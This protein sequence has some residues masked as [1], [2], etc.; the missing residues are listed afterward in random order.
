MQNFTGNTSKNKNQNIIILSDFVESA[1]ESVCF[2]IEN[3]MLNNHE[4][5][6]VQTYKRPKFG[7]MLLKNITPVLKQI[8]KNDLLDLKFKTL[9]HFKIDEG[10]VSIHP[11]EG[12][13]KSV[14]YYKRIF[15]NSDLMVLSMKEAF[16][17][18][19]SNLSGKVC[20]LASNTT[21]PLFILPHPLKE[22]PFKKVLFLANRK[23][24]EFLKKELNNPVLSRIKKA[25]IDFKIAAKNDSELNGTIKK[26]YELSKNYGF[27]TETADIIEKE[28][29]YFSSLPDKYDLVVVDQELV[30]PSSRNA[31]NLKEWVE[32]KNG[33]PILIY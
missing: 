18:A 26:I 20:N 3:L 9:R 25:S 29:E 17:G 21:I 5:A 30:K 11:L 16:P 31:V 24:N 2:S 10:R 1:W 8:V 22:K 14:F 19:E 27:H 12:D 33:V 13:W 6:F 28:E 32:N 23:W 7:Q 15:L 4:L